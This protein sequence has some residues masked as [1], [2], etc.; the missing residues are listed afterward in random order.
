MNNLMNLDR[1][2]L[3]ERMALVLGTAALPA[4]ALAAPRRRATRGFLTP[5]QMR[6]VSA[7]AD[8]IIPASDTP[9][10]LAA[11]VPARIDGLLTNWAAPA[12]RESIVA[13]LGRIEAASRQQKGKSFAALSAAE[14]DAVL[15]PIDAA[16]LKSAPPPPGAPKPTV[17]S[18]TAFVADPGWLKL[19]ELTINLY[20]FS[21]AACTTELIYEHVPGQ[22][23]PSI[24]LTPQSRPY[25]GTG[26]L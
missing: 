11:G 17:F 5:S 18:Q 7:I 23:E 9:G 19:K 20:Y 8:T 15:R 22:F 2:Q 21:E 3:L 10:A 14:R 16:G 26:P 13:S 12:T 1:R 24:K 25:L 4:E 6:L